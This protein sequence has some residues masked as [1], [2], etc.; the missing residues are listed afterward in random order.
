MYIYVPY[1]CLVPE[2]R[3]QNLTDSFRLDLGVVV[4][5]HVGAGSQIKAFVLNPSLS[6]LAYQQ[7]FSNKDPLVACSH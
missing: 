6:C 7:P 1:V 4:S 2:T 5:H 3:R